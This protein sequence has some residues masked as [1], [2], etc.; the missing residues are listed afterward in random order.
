MD[1]KINSKDLKTGRTILHSAC[2]DG[3]INLVKLLLQKSECELN[4][5]TYDGHY[6]FDLARVRGNFDIIRE[7]AVAGA[8]YGDSDEE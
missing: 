4:A 1:A 8:Q 3:N 6:P 5:K 2:V 7:L